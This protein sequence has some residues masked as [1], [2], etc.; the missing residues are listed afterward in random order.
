MS[1]KVG[2]GAECISKKYRQDLSTQAVPNRD[3]LLFDL[4]F[5][6][7]ICRENLDIAI[8]LCVI[9]NMVIVKNIL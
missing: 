6:S 9:C 4:F 2:C 1:E 8:V 5:S 7:A 3:L